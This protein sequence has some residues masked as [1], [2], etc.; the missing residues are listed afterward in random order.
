MWVDLLRVCTHVWLCMCVH[1]CVFCGVGLLV[2]GL[3]I[4]G[5]TGHSK[6]RRDKGCASLLVDRGHWSRVS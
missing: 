1:T 6:L 2:D 3:S 4:L 5:S